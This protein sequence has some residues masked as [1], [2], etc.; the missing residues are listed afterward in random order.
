MS[1]NFDR[2]KI[3]FDALPFERVQE[4]YRRTELLKLLSTES[5]QGKEILEIGPGERSIGLDMLGE[6]IFT[7]IEPIK[8]FA[9]ANAALY[10]KEKPETR[11]SIHSVLVEDYII[12]L[13]G[14][15]FQYVLMSSNL[16]EFED[17]QGILSI[18]RKNLD[19]NSKIIIVVPNNESIH[20]ILG[21]QLGFL[22]STSSLTRTELQMQQKRN[23]SI[24]SLS[25]LL[26][27]CGFRVEKIYTSFIK[28]W[29]HS[30]M[31]SRLDHKIIEEEE[32]DMLYQL[33]GVF[34]PFGSEIFCVAIVE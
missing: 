21:V 25:N 11:I 7:I 8:E 13:P 23:F 5:I 2:Y 31:Q 19:D 32:L 33:S 20:R 4:R 1:K 15:L 27:S 9:D 34:N 3:S 6:N 14:Q 16:H 26:E 29:T 28:P 10:L 24:T 18:L 30:Q 22:D 17:A 12:S